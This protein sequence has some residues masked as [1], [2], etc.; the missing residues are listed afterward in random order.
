MKK[1]K[2]L[3]VLLAAAALVWSL[4]V[5]RIVGY[6][7]DKEP[8]TKTS[9]H[10]QEIRVNPKDSSVLLLNYPDPFLGDLK[11][12]S[13][14]NSKPVT[15]QN[16]TKTRHPSV[17]SLNFQTQR[18]QTPTPKPLMEKLNQTIVFKGLVKNSNDSRQLGILVVDGKEQLIRQGDFVGAWQVSFLAAD[19]VRLVDGVTVKE[20]VKR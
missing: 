11:A 18:H 20:V 10:Q 15:A 19:K 2:N 14:K 5:W 8:I 7:S 12:I 16:I 17:E 9:K 1:P 3:F 4:I 6:H 13:K